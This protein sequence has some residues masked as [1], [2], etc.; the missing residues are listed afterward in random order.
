M[1]VI[2]KHIGAQGTVKS[3]S[4]GYLI[5][6]CVRVTNMLAADWIVLQLVYGHFTDI[7]GLQPIN[8]FPLEYGSPC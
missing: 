6:A 2:N 4:C 3:T 8:E 1:S 7:Y 5:L